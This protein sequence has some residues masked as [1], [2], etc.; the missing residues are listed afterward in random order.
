MK[1]VVTWEARANVTEEA[2]GRSLQVFSKWVPSEGV[3]YKE[4]LSRV[5][6]GGGYAVVETDDAALIAK[7]TNPFSVWF[8]FSVVPVLE[9][10]DSTA[11]AME[12]VAFLQSVS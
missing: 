2:F 12:A 6:G 7:D 4:F 10:G 8:D 9:I 5:D 3:A 1:Y 11:I